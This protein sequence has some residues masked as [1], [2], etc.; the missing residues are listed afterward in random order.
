MLFEG[1]EDAAE[2][3]AQRLAV[4]KDAPDTLVTAL[5]RGGVPVGVVVAKRL[6]LP[7]DIFFVKKIPSPYNKE[8]GIGAI[9]EN[10]YEFLNTQIVSMLNIPKNYIEK[11]EKE[12]LEKI[13]QKRSLYQWPR[14]TVQGKRVIVVDDGIATGSSMYLA[15]KALKEEGAR[16]VIIAAPVAPADA[17][18]E[19]EQIADRVVVLETPDDFMA[20]GQ[21]Y[22]DFHQLSDEEVIEWL[23]F[24]KL[25]I[26]DNA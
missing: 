17:V 6:H 19:L 16:E 20:V 4:F 1:R 18:N 8:A 25:N 3:L 13:A 2:K 12:I 15:A 14:H 9:S 11:T 10:G 24:Y 26:R 22:T 21:F 23:Q 5:P 7:F